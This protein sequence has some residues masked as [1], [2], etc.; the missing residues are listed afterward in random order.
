[1]PWQESSIMEQRQEFVV[2]ASAEG[3]NVSALCRRFGISRET[4]HK[5]I[6]RYRAGGTGALDDLSRRPRASPDRTGAPMEQS[7][8]ELRDKHPAWGGRKLRARLL[9]LGERDVPAAS[10]IT[11]ILRRH[12]RLD[13]ERS[14]Q[15]TAFRRFER[16]G[17]NQLWQMD[18]KGHVPMRTGVR[19]HPL[20]VLDDHS[21]FSIGLR[22]CGNEQ[23]ATVRR[24]LTAIF[25][26]YGLPQMFL[27]DNGPPWGA[28]DGIIGHTRLTLWLLR[29]GINVCHGRPWHP[30]TQGKQERFHRTLKAE[31][32]LRRE[33]R[34]LTH[35]Q[36]EFDAWR[37]V[38]NLERPNEAIGLV[39]PSARYQPSERAY[40]EKPPELEFSPDDIVRRVH[41]NGH[42]C[43]RGRRWYMGGAFI[44]EPLEVRTNA[45]GKIEVRYGPYVVARLEPTSGQDRA[46]LRRV[47]EPLEAAGGDD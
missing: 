44:G 40:P 12:G 8:L 38:Y 29:L 47:P 27:C 9:A 16:S 31:V 1:M 13:D 15:H 10:T 35:A 45:E 5:W 32:L 39:V 17:P 36:R 46:G 14:E 11:Q 7:I 41:R 30:Q 3:A 42:L 20:T 25:R 28:V 43:Y 4:G 37:D 21:R 34:G 22:A 6:A 24:E 23:S 33:L 18:F 19:C 26:R 2:L